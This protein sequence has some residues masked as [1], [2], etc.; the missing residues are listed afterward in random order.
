M[1]FCAS[2]AYY[3]VPLDWEPCLSC[4]YMQTKVNWQPRLDNTPCP[5]DNFKPQ[6]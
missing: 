3:D 6:R 1:R 2:C 4:D 5:W